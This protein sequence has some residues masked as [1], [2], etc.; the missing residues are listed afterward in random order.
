MSQFDQFTPLKTPAFFALAKTRPVAAIAILI[1]AML[2]LA[3]PIAAL[4]APTFTQFAGFV[5]VLAGL[6]FVALIVVVKHPGKG[7]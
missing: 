7:G 5:V 4:R 6:S 2:A 1:V 3:I